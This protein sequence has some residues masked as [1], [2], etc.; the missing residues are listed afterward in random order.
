MEEAKNIDAM[1]IDELI[2]AL[3]TFDT[4]LDEAKGNK[5]K[6]EKSIA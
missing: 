3:Q 6:G 4:N 2:G 1:Q 5:I